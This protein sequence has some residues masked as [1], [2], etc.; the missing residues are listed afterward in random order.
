MFFFSSLRCVVCGM[1]FV[2]LLG[3]NNR[4]LRKKKSH[5]FRQPTWCVYE[6]RD[7]LYGCATFFPILRHRKKQ[8]RIATT[9]GLEFKSNREKN[10]N[11]NKNKKKKQ[12]LCVRK[13]ACTWKLNLKNRKKKLGICT[14]I[15]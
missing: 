12:K 7:F 3:Y 8:K 6:T 14:R 5:G 13:N 2:H 11:K 15:G 9:R 1:C 10:K 4:E